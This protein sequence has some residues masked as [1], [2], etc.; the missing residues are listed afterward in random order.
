MCGFLR[1]YGKQI[2]CH[3]DGPERDR[4]AAGIV[5][6]PECA[7]QLAR[8]LFF[9]IEPGRVDAANVHLIEDKPALGVV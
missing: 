6:M 2:R 4:I 5:A 3:S 1:L 9:E 8:S 7:K